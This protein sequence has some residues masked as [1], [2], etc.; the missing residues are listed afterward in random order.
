MRDSFV[1]FWTTGRPVAVSDMTNTEIGEVLDGLAAGRVVPDGP[2][3]G[4]PET[5]RE[6]LLIE[7]TARELG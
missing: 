5:L 4:S 2:D 1:T 6:R 3:D 7:L